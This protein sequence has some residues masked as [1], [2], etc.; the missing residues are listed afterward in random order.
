MFQRQ[1]NRYLFRNSRN[2]SSLYHNLTE[3]C[4]RSNNCGTV[5]D[6]YAYYDWI[7]LLVTL[8][9][10]ILCTFSSPNNIAKAGAHWYSNK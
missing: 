7:L 4:I 2:L 3:Y 10:R 6:F 1:S 8:Y 9:M 5:D